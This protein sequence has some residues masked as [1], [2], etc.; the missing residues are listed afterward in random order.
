MT[1]RTTWLRSSRLGGQPVTSEAFTVVPEFVYSPI[2]PA[3]VLPE[4]DVTFFLGK[5]AGL[6]RSLERRIGSFLFLIV[7]LIPIVT[8]ILF[9]PRCRWTATNMARAN[10]CNLRHLRATFEGR[11]CHLPKGARIVCHLPSRSIANSLV[12]N[13]SATEVNQWRCPQRLT[14]AARKTS[15]APSSGRA[16]TTKN[17]PTAGRGAVLS[18]C[19]SGGE[20]GP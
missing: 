17:R 11:H 10:G 5:R 2:V 1:H 9:A 7:S 6:L 19:H 20:F 4:R 15:A 13:V 14:P 16:A 3:C 18:P 8:F 12:G